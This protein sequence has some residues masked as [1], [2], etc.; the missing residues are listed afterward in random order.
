M[1]IRSEAKIPQRR[2]IVRAADQRPVVLAIAILDR[3][4]VDAGDADAHKA[5]FVE[6]MEV[7]FTDVA[8]L[9]V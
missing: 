2:V 4:I 8:A 1:M 5:V 7:V 9:E 6:L 3:N